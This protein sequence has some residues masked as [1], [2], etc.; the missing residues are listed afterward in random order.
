MYMKIESRCWI[1]E[2]V[3][4]IELQVPVGQIQLLDSG[5]GVLLAVMGNIPIL[6]RLSFRAAVKDSMVKTLEKHVTIDPNVI[7]EEIMTDLA[8]G[9]LAWLEEP[10]EEGGEE[11]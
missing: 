11:S 9:G 7:A 4:Y 2:G 10:K 6:Q 1:E 5:E 8:A 3:A